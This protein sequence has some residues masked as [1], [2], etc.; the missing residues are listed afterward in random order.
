MADSRIF[1]LRDNMSAVSIVDEIVHYLQF[2][3]NMTPRVAENGDA[4]F[5]QADEDD[6][7]LK[8]YTGMSKDIEIQVIR[9]GSDSVIVNVG[10]GSL[11]DKAAAGA[12]GM[13][14]FTPLVVTA[15]IGAYGQNKLIDEIFECVEKF[16]LADGRPIWRRT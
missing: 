12:A 9:N 2:E 8:K 7:K 13:L 14:L 10:H 11:A 6:N 15:A 16:I 3:K 1:Q 4:F 5:I